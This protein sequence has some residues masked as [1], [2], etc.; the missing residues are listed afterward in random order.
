VRGWCRRA[1]F[2]DWVKRGDRLPAALVAIL[3]TLE[4]CGAM[5][6]FA[7]IDRKLARS[8]LILVCL[9]FLFLSSSLPALA[10]ERAISL[11]WDDKGTRLQSDW[12]YASRDPDHILPHFDGPYGDKIA[13][14]AI[15]KLGFPRPI[16]IIQKIDSG[17]CGYPTYFVIRS[18]NLAPKI[19]LEVCTEDVKISPRKT[20]GI[21]DLLMV[22]GLRQTTWVWNGETWF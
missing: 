4:A 16:L 17:S 3:S 15:A 21:N 9:A 18:K 22:G 1:V 7:V 19:V 12:D 10:N 2:Q 5:R 8:A 11:K 13:R 20:K 6:M 14:I